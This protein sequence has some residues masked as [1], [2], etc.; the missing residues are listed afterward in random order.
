MPGWQR[1][2]WS[3]LHQ[4]QIKYKSTR[5]AYYN[6]VKYRIFTSSQK[7]K[8]EKDRPDCHQDYTMIIKQQ[9][10]R[11]N[12]RENTHLKKKKLI[13]SFFLQAK[14]VGSWFVWEDPPPIPPRSKKFSVVYITKFCADLEGVRLFWKCL[15]Y[16]I[17]AKRYITEISIHYLLPFAI[18]ISVKPDIYLVESC[19]QMVCIKKRI[20]QPYRTRDH[21]LNSVLI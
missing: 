20:R 9:R 7:G 13:F 2:E 12:K 17:S 19:I 10:L 15:Q 18:K 3:K 11:C 21:F 1:F 5:V 6:S 14:Y 4:L 16:L 8:C